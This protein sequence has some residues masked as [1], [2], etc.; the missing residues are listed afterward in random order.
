MWFNSMQRE[1]PYQGLTCQNLRETGSALNTGGAWLSSARVA[2]CWVKSNNERNPRFSASIK[3]GTLE[4]LPVTN[5]RKV[6]MTSVSMPLRLGYTY[7]YGQGQQVSDDKQPANRGSDCRPQLACMKLESLVIAG[8]HYCGEYVPGLTHRP[9]HMEA[10]L[11]EVVT[12]TA[13]RDA[14]GQ[15]DDWGE[16]VTR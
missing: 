9:S 16:V 11:A 1:E 4:R 14:E 15:A 10:G 8:Q 12:L 2:R 7:Y 3:L 6:G 5:R 13:R